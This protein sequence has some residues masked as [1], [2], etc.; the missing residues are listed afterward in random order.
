M[1]IDKYT[2]KTELNGMG[3]LTGSLPAAEQELV[4]AVTESTN[5]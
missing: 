2:N 3:G 4:M 1:F 5:K